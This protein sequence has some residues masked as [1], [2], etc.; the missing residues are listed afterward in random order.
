[1]QLLFLEKAL[2]S[3]QDH[4]QRL[5]CHHIPSSPKNIIKAM[6]EAART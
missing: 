5:T 3:N 2:K 6:H 1:M 4:A